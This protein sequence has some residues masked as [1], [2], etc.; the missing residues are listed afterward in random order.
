[1]VS[2]A[3]QL[4]STIQE[5]GS[6]ESNWIACPGVIH[7]TMDARDEALRKYRNK[8]LQH[9]ELSAKLKSSVYPF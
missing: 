5:G 1:V 4:G 9:K 2:S 3:T 6:A 8:L 7:S